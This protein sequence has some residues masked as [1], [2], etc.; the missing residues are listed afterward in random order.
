MC[1]ELTSSS[2]TIH[3]SVVPIVA[4]DIGGDYNYFSTFQSIP[5]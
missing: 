4:D 5:G 3:T 2:I 1:D